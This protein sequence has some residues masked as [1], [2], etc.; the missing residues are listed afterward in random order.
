MDRFERRGKTVCDGSKLQMTEDNIVLSVELFGYKIRV[1][2]EP[3]K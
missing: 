3:L 1:S 2:A